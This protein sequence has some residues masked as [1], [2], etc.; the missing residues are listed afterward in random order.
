M[1]LHETQETQGTNLRSKETKER[2]LYN[3]KCSLHEKTISL[4]TL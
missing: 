1:Q 2:D 3:R 4:E